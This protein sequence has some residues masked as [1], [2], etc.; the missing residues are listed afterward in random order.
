VGRAAAA[1]APRAQQ[2]RFE[3]TGAAWHRRRVPINVLTWHHTE[4]GRRTDC[5]RFRIV[6]Q[7]ASWQ[8]LDADW[9]PLGAAP[10]IAAAQQLAER[11]VARGRGAAPRE[12]ANGN[13]QSKIR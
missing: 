13:A 11:V 6:H 7:G 1:R 9:N 2:L 5:E 4:F 10:T 8:L 3:F 12:T